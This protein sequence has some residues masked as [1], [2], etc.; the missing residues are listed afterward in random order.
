MKVDMMNMP[1]NMSEAYRVVMQLRDANK[2]KDKRIAELEKERDEHEMAYETIVQA[3]NKCYDI[4]S[5]DKNNSE[6]SKQLCL[7]IGYTVPSELL[8][9]RD[10]EQQTIGFD[11]A[12]DAALDLDL[13]EN[14]VHV[15]NLIKEQAKAKGGA[16]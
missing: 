14:D 12:I 9:I 15:C 4:V 11:A 1:K 3:L 6:L 5:K 13:I 16:D 10:L 2:K 7:M 8:E